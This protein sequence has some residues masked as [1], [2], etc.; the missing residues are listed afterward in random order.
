M[1]YDAKPL[2]PLDPAMD[3]SKNHYWTYHSL[4]ALLACKRPLTTSQDEDLFIAVHQVCEIAFHQMIIDLDRVLDALDGALAGEGIVG[5]TGEAR[6]FLARVNQLW[7]TVNTTM[8]ILAGMRAFAE[9]RTSI[10]PTSGFQSYQFRQIEI[11][12]GIRRAYWT[13]GT[14]DPQGKLHVAET[15]F[16][17]VFGPEVEAWFER[18]AQ[19]SL[20][21]RYE[22]LVARAR[23]QSPADPVGALKAHAQAGPLL[24]ALLEFDRMKRAFHRSHLNLAV[25]QLRRVG[26]EVGTGGTSFRTYLAKYEQELA[27]LFPGLVGAEGAAEAA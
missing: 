2:P 19:R 15:E 5:D 22:A 4:P 20:L 14:A 23:A 25:V 18:Y 3:A 26:V 7:R 8:P 27:P 6:Y 17:R 11:M 21:A 1:N 16:D 13:G 10:G 12:A 9:F 24:E